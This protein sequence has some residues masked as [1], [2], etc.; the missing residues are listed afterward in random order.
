MLENPRKTETRCNWNEEI[1]AQ[2]MCGRITLKD[3]SVSKSVF[4]TKPRDA[5]SRKCPGAAILM[6]GE[7]S[8]SVQVVRPSPISLF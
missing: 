6:S 7:G 2:S 3:E 1:I 5:R 8:D 4:T